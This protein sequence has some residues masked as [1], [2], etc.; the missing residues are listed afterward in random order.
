MA[1]EVIKGFE[2]DVFIGEDR[3]I[4]VSNVDVTIDRQLEA[5]YEC[6]DIDPV[7]VKAGIRSITGSIGRGLVN[8][9]LLAMIIGSKSSAG[10]VWTI[11]S[12]DILL[13]KTSVSGE[14]VACDGSTTVFKLGYS[15]VI[16]HTFVL[17]SGGNAW[18]V[19]GVDYVIDYAY[20]YLTF[21]VPQAADT[22]TCDYDY[23]RSFTMRLRLQ[24]GDGL[25][26]RTDT[27]LRGCL[28]KDWNISYAN[29]GSTVI[30]KCNFTAKSGDGMFIGLP[31]SGI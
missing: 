4:R 21:A 7:E 29:D 2:G 15:P 26:Q 22:W 30:E 23:G 11:S 1:V 20:G 17:K 24:V 3:V 6:G 25:D 28:L 31:V 13:P 14:S 9:Y 16:Q 5:F 12:Q 10:G 8:G 19:E 27:V 18:G